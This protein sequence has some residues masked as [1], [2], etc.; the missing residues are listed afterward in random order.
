MGHT[1][2]SA[3]GSKDANA[4]NDVLNGKV[5]AT[6]TPGATTVADPTQG[7]SAGQLRNRKLLAGSLKMASAGLNSAQPQQQQAPPVNFNTQGVP[8]SQSVIPAPLQFPFY[9]R[10]PGNY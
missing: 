8:Q 9:G 1:I 3:F 4:T 10:M 2:A 6:G 7:M 5:V